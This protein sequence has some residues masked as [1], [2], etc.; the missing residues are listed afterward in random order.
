MTV[1]DAASLRRQIIKLNRRLQLLE[2]E[3]KERAKREMIMYSIT[4]KVN[5]EL[6]P[7]SWSKLRYAL[8]TTSGKVTSTQHPGRRR[9]AS[10]GTKSARY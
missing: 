3:N 10:C 9:L 7:L 2:E 6:M 4:K 5:Y 1:V 8:N